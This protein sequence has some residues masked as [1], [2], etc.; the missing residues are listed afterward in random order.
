MTQSWGL[1]TGSSYFPVMS[2]GWRTDV[3]VGRWTCSAAGPIWAGFGGLREVLL[4][5][6]GPRDRDVASAQSA[7]CHDLCGECGHQDDV[8][9][10]TDHTDDSDVEAGRGQVPCELSNPVARRLSVSFKEQRSGQDTEL[11]TAGKTEVL[12]DCEGLEAPRLASSLTFMPQADCCLP[13]KAA[14]WAHL[15]SCWRSTCESFHP[16]LYIC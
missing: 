9:C 10:E 7:P 3:C 6:G 5:I 2:A 12:H 1:R 11:N 15:M 4:D 14:P 13:R 16:T 8:R